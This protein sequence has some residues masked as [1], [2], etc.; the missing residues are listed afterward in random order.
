MQIQ[1]D[2]SW[3]AVK[4]GHFPGIGLVVVSTEDVVGPITVV[5]EKVVELVSVVVA[6]VGVKLVEVGGIEVEV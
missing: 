3:G 6:G 4:Y 2:L 1:S 5:G